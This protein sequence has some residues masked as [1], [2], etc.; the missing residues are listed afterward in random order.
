MTLREQ[1]PLATLTTFKVGGNAMYVA[2]CENE[3][4]VQAAILF[5]EKHGL[6]WYVIGG[7]SN[8]LASDEGY[9]GV[10]LHIKVAGISF[11][12]DNGVMRVLAGAGVLWDKLVEE[13]VTRELWGLENLAGIPGTVGGAPVQNIGAYGAD[14]SETLLYVDAFDLRTRQLMRF[15]KMECSFGY[16][17]SRFKH[18]P[19]LII[20]RVAF[21][22]NTQGTPR[23]EYADLTTRAQEGA[24]L[25]SPLAIATI[26]REIR[27]KKFP[28]LSHSGT[29]GSFFKNPTITLQEYTALQSKY[30]NIKGFVSNDS[31]KVSLAWILDHI[32]HM[33][34]FKKGAARL[35]EQQPLVLVAD[36]KATQR[37]VSALAQE[38]T[39]RVYEATGITIEPEVRSL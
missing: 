31:V 3:K 5:S 1:I 6:P 10:I 29:A 24:M 17:E 28:D 39:K 38:V 7:G 30:P 21:G 33:K 27:S 32:L 11:E 18:D 36:S 22:L 19:S 12:Q 23:V 8:I 16:R 35:Y 2:E 25:D 13:A 20:V 15:T 26:V 34:G 4:D 14:V 9:K 37:E